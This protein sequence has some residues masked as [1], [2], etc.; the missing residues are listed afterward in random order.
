[1]LLAARVL[2]ATLYLKDLSAPPRNRSG[3]RQISL[4]CKKL[5][6]AL[7][8]R[9]QTRQELT[10]VFC[11]WVVQQSSSVQTTTARN[12]NRETREQERDGVCLGGRA[13]ESIFRV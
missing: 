2:E 3:I 7:V 6:R 9:T 8:T 12:T 1:M 4:Q 13:G 5:A 11:V 10:S